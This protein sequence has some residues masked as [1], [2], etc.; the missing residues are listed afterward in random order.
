MSINLLLPIVIT[1]LMAAN[2]KFREGMKNEDDNKTK[3]K[4]MNGKDNCKEDE[5]CPKGKM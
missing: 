5:D 1:G 3:E 2:N 4:M